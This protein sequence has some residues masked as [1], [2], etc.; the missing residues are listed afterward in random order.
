MFLFSV[1]LLSCCLQTQQNAEHCGAGALG[2][3]EP[4]ELCGLTGD[5]VLGSSCSAGELKSPRRDVLRNSD[6]RSQRG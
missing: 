6:F 1:L 2:M 3:R 5:L 4:V